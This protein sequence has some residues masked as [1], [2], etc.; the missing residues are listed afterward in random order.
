MT[1]DTGEKLRQ[2]LGGLSLEDFRQIPCHGF[3]NSSMRISQAMAW[4]KG[5][6]FVGTGRGPIRPLGLSSQ[7]LEEERPGLSRLTARLQ[8]QGDRDQESGTQIWRLDPRSEEWKQVYITRWVL[9]IDGREHP[10]DRSV[11]ARGIFKGK[12]DSEPALYFGVRSME[13]QVVILRCIDGLRFEETHG[14]GLGLGRVDVPSIRTLCE[15][16]SRLYTSPVGKNHDCGALDDI[17]TDFPIVFESDDPYKGHWR[18]VSE[19]GFGDAENLSIDEMVAFNGYLYAGTYNAKKGYQIWKTEAIGQP[20]YRWRKII[21]EGAYRGPVNSVPPTM[22][23]F[24]G[25][26]YVGS[27]LEQQ[28]KGHTDSYGPFGAELIRIYPDDTWDLVV[29]IQ[30]FTPQGFKRPLSGAGPGFDDV[31]TQAFWRMIEYNG[32]LYLGVSDWR[33]IPTYLPRPGR[34]RAD[35]SKS[36]L[37]YLMNRTVEYDGGFSF[38]RSRDGIT[39]LPITTDGFNDNPYTYGIREFAA[40]PY[41]LFV[42]TASSRPS[43][44]GGGPEV[45]LGFQ[46]WTQSD[47]RE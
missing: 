17:R 34:R 29:G 28:G 15:F 18:A 26:L 42:A 31:F 13:G 21:E 27:G 36:K 39:W 8:N 5:Y 46:D 3:S 16:K 35:L 44:L 22:Y 11:R 6:L 41:G 12:S 7:K 33:F 38:W 45:W 10:R 43:W 32:W 4:Y 40:S 14:T 1:I 30:R 19:P 9:G 37:Q 23:V 2:G 25:I 24:Q 20:P 47:D